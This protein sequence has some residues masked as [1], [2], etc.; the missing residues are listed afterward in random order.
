MMLCKVRRAG[1]T[2]RV[3]GQGP[4]LLLPRIDYLRIEVRRTTNQYAR[5]LKSVTG[6]WTVGAEL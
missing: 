6:P 1:G 3:Y 5:Q 2:R 4:G